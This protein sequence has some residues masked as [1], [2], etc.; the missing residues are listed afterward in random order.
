MTQ[1]TPS[2]SEEEEEYVLPSGTK[3]ALIEAAGEL[4]AQLGAKGAGIRTIAERAGVN[5]GSIHYHFGGKGNLYRAALEYVLH[6]RITKQ[7]AQ[8][9]VPPSATPARVSE[10]LRLLT[11]KRLAAAWGGGTPRWHTRLLTRLLM[12]GPPDALAWF[13]ERVFQPDFRLFRRIVCLARPQQP[14]RETRKLFYVFVSQMIFYSHHREKVIRTFGDEG[15]TA[16]L[17]EELT[18]YIALSLTRT[19]GLPDPGPA[20]PSEE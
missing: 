9:P 11:R 18:D 14:P 3:L 6:Q 5:L 20:A 2:T 13:D 19:L 1:V 7:N 10:L 4:F 15:S 8:I 17:P 16:S 12:E